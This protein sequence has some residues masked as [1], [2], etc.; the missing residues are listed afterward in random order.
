MCASFFLAH[1]LQRDSLF[2]RTFSCGSPVSHLELT[3]R[4]E[5]EYS[6]AILDD[7][8]GTICLGLSS[9]SQIIPTSSSSSSG[10]EQRIGTKITSCIF[11]RTSENGKNLFYF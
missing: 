2:S 7:F 8:D 10:N 1:H 9:L 11:K 5:M 3:E 6:A 4:E